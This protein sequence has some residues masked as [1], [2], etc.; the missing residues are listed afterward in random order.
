MSGAAAAAA[1]SS[2]HASKE[3]VLLHLTLQS[4]SAVTLAVAGNF[5][6]P[7]A[8]EVAVVRGGGQW[9]AMLRP[10]EH[11]GKMDTVWEG[12]VFGVIRCMAPFRL[13]GQSKVSG[14][15]HAVGLA[16]SDSL[17][18]PLTVSVHLCVAVLL[19]VFRWHS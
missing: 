6:A 12:N 8:Q 4:S 16:G 1:S 9:L 13:V 5:S 15:L 19:Y 7:R 3:M 2:G 14:D 17:V 18:D 10:N 11:S